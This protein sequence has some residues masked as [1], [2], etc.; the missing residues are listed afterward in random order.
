MTVDEARQELAAFPS[1]YANNWR[2]WLRV[3]RSDGSLGAEVAAEFGSVL[4]KWN[5]TRPYPMRRPRAEAVHKPPFIDDLLEAARPY[6][7]TI[8]HVSIREFH[9][10]DASRIAA[11]RALWDIFRELPQHHQASCVGISKA[12][13]LLTEGRIGPAFDS[14][15]KTNLQLRYVKDCDIWI[16]SLRAVNRDIRAF[17][18]RHGIRLEDFVPNKLAPIAVGRVYD[19]IAGPRT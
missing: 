18:A 5:A 3:Y 17:E 8:G 2:M 16:D 14:F 15:V 1:S 4:R 13:M 9:T 11:L 10:A 7:R 19:M 12:I 6:V